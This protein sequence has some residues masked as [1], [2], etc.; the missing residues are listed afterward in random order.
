MTSVCCD[1]IGTIL[2]DYDAFYEHVTNITLQ[3]KG[4]KISDYPLNYEGT[5]KL[6]LN[7]SHIIQNCELDYT[8]D[9]E[10][11]TECI[12]L[13]PKDD[14]KMYKNFIFLE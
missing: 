9:E 14:Q 3:R 5:M 10:Y 11:L 2:F 4:D 12:K 13:L 6:S 7:D 1:E 8:L